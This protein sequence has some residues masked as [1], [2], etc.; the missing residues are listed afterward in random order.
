MRMLLEMPTT[1]RARERMLSV[2]TYVPLDGFL[3]LI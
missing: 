1:E 3:R 2:W